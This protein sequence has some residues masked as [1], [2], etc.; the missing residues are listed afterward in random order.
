[1][2]PELRN[3]TAQ[4]FIRALVADGFIWT[5][6]KGSHRVYYHKDGRR[7]IVSFHRPSATFPPKTLKSMIDGARWTDDDLRRLGLIS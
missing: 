6:N 3:V 7:V 4:E 1:M 2:H 5:R